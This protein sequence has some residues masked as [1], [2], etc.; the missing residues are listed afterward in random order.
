VD[1]VIRLYPP[2]LAALRVLA[3]EREIGGHRLPAGTGVMVAIPLVH[4]DP[5]SFP[6]PLRLEPGRFAGTDRPAAFMPFGDGPRRCPGEDLARLEL[7]VVV[8][9]VL[10]RV[11]LRLPPRRERPVQRATVLPPNRSGLAWI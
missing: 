11:E 1:E 8:P 4:R 5:R 2:G 7:D 9:A 10:D 6:D 3:E